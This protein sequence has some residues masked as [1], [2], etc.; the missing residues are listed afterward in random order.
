MKEI[1]TVLSLGIP[2]A[3]VV[4]SVQYQEPSNVLIKGTTS[5]WSYPEFGVKVNWP[6][7]SGNVSALF[8][9]LWM[10]GPLGRKTMNLS[11]T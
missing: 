2:F 10:P 4:C 7:F 11:G 1:S 8:R 6:D 5:E 9:R 3:K